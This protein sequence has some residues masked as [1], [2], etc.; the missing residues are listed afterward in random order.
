MDLKKCQIFTPTE[1]VN[2]MLDKVGYN[3]RIFGKKII[4]NS[5]GN[6]NFL[7]EILRRFLQEAKRKKVSFCS[8]ILKHI[9]FIK[10]YTDNCG[11]CNC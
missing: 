10:N 8:K 2:L 5:C 9:F 3:K 7:V 1:I 4:D 11:D 6:G